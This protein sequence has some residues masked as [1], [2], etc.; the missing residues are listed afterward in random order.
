METGP[1]PQAARTPGEFVAAMRQLR[2]WAGLSYRQLERRAENAGDALP[3]ATI[4]GAL[5]RED[6]PREE[7]LI[8][9]V[10][11]CGADEATIAA[12][13]SARRRLAVTAAGEV[14]KEPDGS[15]A[16]GASDGPG[17]P[18][19]PGASGASGASGGPEAS[20]GSGVVAQPGGGDTAAA[21]GDG[22]GASERSGDGHAATAEG[23]APDNGLGD[24]P[25]GK[26]VV[27]AVV[28]VDSDEPDEPQD[29]PRVP[30]RRARYAT[31]ALAGALAAAGVVLFAL[32][33]SPQAPANAQPED[34]PRTTVTP[35]VAPP[36]PSPSRSA[37]PSKDP[38]TRPPTRPSSAPSSPD[39][40]PGDGP[41]RTTPPEAP[42]P[43]P[44]PGLPEPGPVKIHPADASGR[45]LTEGRERNGR[46]NREIAVQRSCASAPLP[47]VS[48]ES[49]GTGIYRITWY[50]PQ[51]G[52]G[53]L[54]VDDGLTGSGALLSPGDCTGADSQLFR[55]EP[56]GGGHRMRP[57]HSGLCVGFLRPV[58]DGAEAVQASCT[59]GSDQAFHFSAG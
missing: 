59:G 11:A 18:E 36:A 28:L 12:W 25:D 44:G 46:T 55:L 26:P 7:L 39:G 23:D 15:G 6:L 37:S 9:F 31:T 48:L 16:S 20:D 32:W 24:E 8:A 47:R 43:G 45:C 41:T 54:G 14:A 22:P 57:V 4:S 52:T 21:E 42:G 49:A 35:P 2:G 58:A 1:D 10:R 53:C 29:P 30:R 34:R 13:R 56:S 51:N 17:G 3:R 5:A 38:S 40:K 50:H 33:P 19:G 27:P